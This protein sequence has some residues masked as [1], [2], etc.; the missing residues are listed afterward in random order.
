MSPALCFC[1]GQED[2]TGTCVVCEV[3]STALKMMG[4]IASQ[5]V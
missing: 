5:L 1:K 2:P 3:G 4:G